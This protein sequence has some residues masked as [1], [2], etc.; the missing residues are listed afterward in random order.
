MR[1]IA[2]KLLAAA[3]VVVPAFTA[4]ANA[5]PRQQLE[6][7]ASKMAT[8]LAQVCPRAGYNDTAA[9]RSCADALQNATFLPINQD[10]ILWGGDQATLK[11]K[12]RHLTHF[13][14]KVFQAMYLPL[15]TFTGNWSLAHDDRE[16]LDIIEVEAFFRNQLPA[17]EYPYPFWHNAGKWNDYEKMST[18]R[19]YLNDKGRIFVGTRGKSGNEAARGQY[20]HVDH[21]PFQKDQWQWTDDKGQLQPTITLFSARYQPA[22]PHLGR[23]DQ[24]YRAFAAEMRQASCVG[25]HSPQNPSDMEQLTLLQTPSHAAG[26]IDRVIAQVEQKKMPLDDIGMAKEIDPKLRENILKTAQAFRNEVAAADAW[27]ATR[28]N[29]GAVAFTTDANKPTAR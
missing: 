15:M 8:Q 2:L 21:E 9:Y 16:N 26:E 22:N 23:L 29:R 27:E 19:F 11:I 18:V 14:T 28:P 6:E 17:G 7:M 10:G 4:Q 3:A 20:A 13:N 5:M 25:C 1:R 12:K 24:T